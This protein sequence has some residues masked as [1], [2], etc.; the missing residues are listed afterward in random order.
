MTDLRFSGHIN[1]LDNI[2]HIHQNKN[3]K[4]TSVTQA[5]HTTNVISYFKNTI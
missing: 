3:D 5:I 2:Y 4:D 1:I